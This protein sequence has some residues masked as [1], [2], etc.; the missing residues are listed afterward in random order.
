[1]TY[2]E[3]LV[4]PLIEKEMADRLQK[5]KGLSADEET[6]LLA[7]SNEQK[8]IVAENDRKLKNEFLTAAPAITHGTVK[9]N[10]KYK[11]YLTMV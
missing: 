3:D 4:L 8:K 9:G 5:F 11:N 7:L 1:M 2:K 10:E 6:K